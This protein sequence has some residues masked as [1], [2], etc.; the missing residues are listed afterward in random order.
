MTNNQIIRSFLGI[1]DRARFSNKD[2]GDYDPFK[3]PIIH[4]QISG[5]EIIPLDVTRLWGK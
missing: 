3:N 4:K 2:C 1:D 5:K